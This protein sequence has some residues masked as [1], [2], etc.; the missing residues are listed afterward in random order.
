MP[1]WIPA[2][3]AAGAVALIGKIIQ[4][5]YNGQLGYSAVEDPEGIRTVA[6]FATADEE[7][8][9]VAIAADLTG[10]IE[11]PLQVTHD[12]IRTREGVD[13]VRLSPCPAGFTLALTRAFTGPQLDS[14]A[15]EILGR[16]HHALVSRGVRELVWH[17]RQ[18][19]E[20]VVPHAHPFY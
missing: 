19:R 6:R 15:V 12:A 11:G 20:L 9:L 10:P 7:Q 13:I 4:R 18:D 1:F 8:L 3:A 14:R 2:M 16:L 5:H 17:A